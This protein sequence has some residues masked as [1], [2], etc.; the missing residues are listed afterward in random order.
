MHFENLPRAAF[1]IYQCGNERS[2]ACESQI[3]RVGNGISRTITH[4]HV[5]DHAAGGGGKERE[6]NKPDDV[7][8][9]LARDGAA[10][11]AVEH[12]TDQIQAA[13]ER[14]DGRVH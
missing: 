2:G 11:D 3:E 7:E 8:I 1:E 5:A 12:D 13:V 6:K 4:A 14:I 9:A 10:D